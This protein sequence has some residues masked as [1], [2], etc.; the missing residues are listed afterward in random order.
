M[1]RGVV[2]G[3]S[4]LGYDVKNGQISVNPETAEIVR[5]IFQKYAIE[6]VGTSEIARFL[7]KNGYRT[8]RGSS[9]W[10]PS[11]V[12]K[13]LKNEKYAGDLVQKK[14]YTPDFLTHEKKTNNGQVPLI[15]IENH[16]E[17]I[18]SKQIF[19][20]AQARLEKNNKHRKGEGHSN[21]YIFSGKIRCA[22]CGNYFVGRIRY[23]KD[24]TGI[25]RWS[26][27]TATRGGREACGI[28]KLIRDDDALQMLKEAVRS[29]QMDVAEIVGHVADLATEAI[30]DSETEIGDDPKKLGSEIER[31]EHK[32]EAMMDSYFSGEISKEEM[33]A[34]KRK[35]DVKT[36]DLV[37]RQQDAELRK[38]Q[39]LDCHSLRAS[40]QF[41]LTGIL[42]GETESQ[43]FCKSLLDSLTV[44]PDRHM[45][46]RLLHLPQIFDF[47]G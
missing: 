33:L 36:A 42:K 31:L 4:L 41:Y 20:M 26:C 6:Q 23:R 9:N 30:Q 3:Q 18:V 37:R 24:G 29:L 27:A 22:E 16:H 2:F 45:E 39:K 11:A 28:G 14:T 25:R 8:A 17:A 44:F 10:T 38:I 19:H 32:R 40:M 35:Y 5:L 7:T 43:V 12:I 47:L 21:R 1:E 46:L 15:T 34:M 13:I